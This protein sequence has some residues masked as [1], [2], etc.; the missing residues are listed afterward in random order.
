MSYPKQ[1][2]PKPMSAA[3]AS[4]MVRRMIHRESSGPRECERAMERIEAK[5]GIGFWT[6]DHFRKEKAKTC[7][8]TLFARIK[9]AFVDHCG[10]QAARLLQEAE[11]AQA[12][13]YDDDVA[14][15]E[16]QIRALASRLEAAKS[17]QAQRGKMK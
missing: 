5:Y 3:E 15:I 1:G 8:V 9:A 7:D 12:V 11:T 2:H 13:R 4:F 17:D 16:D 10:K 6:L 14:A